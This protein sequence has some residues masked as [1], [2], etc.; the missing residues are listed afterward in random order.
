MGL[1]VR[2]P[3]RPRTA[4]PSRLSKPCPAPIVC[5]TLRSPI[6]SSAASTNCGNCTI[7]VSAAA[8]GGLGKTQLAVE[9]VHRF[10]QCY[11]AG[12]FWV[13]ADQG[14]TRLIQVIS[15]HAKIEVDG[16]LC[17][18]AQLDTIWAALANRAA[19]LVVLD[20]F[21]ETVPLRPWL[22][23]TGASRVLVTTRRRDLKLATVPVAAF[24]G[25]EGVRLLNIGARQIPDSAET[26]ALVEAVGGLGL[27]LELLRVYLNL[28]TDVSPAELRIALRAKG[29]LPLLARF[30]ESYE[31]E[32]PT[33]HERNVAATFQMSWGLASESARAVLSVMSH[34]AP[35]PV[36]L[37]LLRAVL[38]WTEADAV[39][40][41]LGD[42]VAECWQLSLAERN[43]RGEPS[44]H[45]LL[46]KFAGGMPESERW[47]SRVRLCITAEM[48]RVT[49]NHDTRAFHELE[50][51][52]PH[53]AAVVE[54]AED[55]ADAASQVA[56]VDVLDYVG[57]HHRKRGRYAAAE[58]SRRKALASAGRSFEP[59]HPSIA[60]S[61]SNLATVLQDL[62]EL[63]EARDLL[64][65]ALASLEQRLPAGHPNIATVRGNLMGVEKA[66]GAG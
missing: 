21:P 5:P 57:W 59:G 38:E 64:R 27:A 33:G 29:E 17:E 54:A 62:G 30:A 22:P 56:V 51:V 52:L 6:D 14:L 65:K 23:V 13:E 31:D 45:R 12:V 2:T 35:E 42:A 20:N 7:G 61:Q 1:R 36:P 49:D 9:Y 10:G 43:S 11:P 47:L 40:D 50:G 25:E 8:S 48:G 15:Q 58:I 44:A 53:A 4:P 37:R 55:S 32:L 34:L 19:S 16:R 41:R 3:S 24:T 26:R 66:M 39:D 46:L 63:P 28:R 18:Q 60:I